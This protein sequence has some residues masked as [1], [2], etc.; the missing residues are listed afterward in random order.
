M[1]PTGAAVFT[2]YGV[3][4]GAKPPTKQLPKLRITEVSCT[5]HCGHDL[6]VA[7]V[8]S[9]WKRHR[10]GVTGVACLLEYKTRYNVELVNLLWR[11][12]CVY[13]KKWLT[14]VQYNKLR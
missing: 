13:A 5:H 8:Q 12:V 9:M 2:G 7:M 14:A 4:Y 6:Q 10:K 11:C 3:K 1:S